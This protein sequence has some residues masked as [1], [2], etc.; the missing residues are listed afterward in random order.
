[1][2]HQALAD[3]L[4]KLVGG[5]QIVHCLTVSF[6]WKFVPLLL[7]SCGAVFGEGVRITPPD[8]RGAKQPQVA[9]SGDGKIHVTFAQDQ[10]IYATRSSDTGRTFDRVVEIGA[11]DKLALGMRRGPRIAVT[12]QNVVVT[13]IS[14]SAGNL[15][16]W[17]SRDAGNSWS[18]RAV[19]NSVTNSAR[20][21]M[22]ALAGDGK[23]KFVS[24]WLDLRNG[25][26]ELWSSISNDTGKTWEANRLVYKSPDGTIC[27]CCHPSA[28]F[29]EDGKI[30]VMWR[31][32][33][34]GNRDMYRAESIDGGKSFGP[35]EKIGTGTWSLAGC[36]M[37]GG[38]LSVAGREMGYTWRREAS[39]YFTRE[40]GSETLLAGTG[41]H[42]VVVRNGSEFS[43]VWQDGG[44]LYWRFTESSPVQLFA[45]N[46]G[47]AASDWSP[48]DQK[49][50]VVWESSDGIYIAEANPR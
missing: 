45:R 31:N 39:L 1:V 41:T 43:Y 47:Y 22:H 9:I 2:L 7:L 15:F 48:K 3:W 46:A 18:E 29:G 28:V 44:N 33:L 19:I 26:T 16:T 36:P 50:F 23:S 30:V 34:K 12:G 27:E 35:A 4:N 21:G 5:G 38:N 25:K 8:F 20:E 49:G 13:A 14:H 17:L 40:P 37:D 6:N 42:P 10:K 24:V 11:L 32:W